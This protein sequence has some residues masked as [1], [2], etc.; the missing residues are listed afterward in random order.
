MI[1]TPSWPRVSVNSQI[2]DDIAATAVQGMNAKKQVMSAHLCTKISGHA[3]AR[4]TIRAS[5]AGG[6]NSSHGRLRAKV[7]DNQSP[8]Y[9]YVT[10]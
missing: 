2:V 3:R 5:H 8:I 7:H 4:K 10:L 6:L 9:S 1:D